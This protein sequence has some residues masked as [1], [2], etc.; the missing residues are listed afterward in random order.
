MSLTGNWRR[1]TFLA[2][3]A[4]DASFVFIAAA[5]PVL[6]AR[7]ARSPKQRVLPIRS[8]HSRQLSGASRT[9][10]RHNASLGVASAA[11]PVFP[12]AHSGDKRLH[13]VWSFFVLKFPIKGL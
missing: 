10:R 7:N 2:N 11:L 6:P 3:N 4:A 9:S 1:V 13:T 12:A 5:L 8:L